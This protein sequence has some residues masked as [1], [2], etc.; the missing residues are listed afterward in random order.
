MSSNHSTSTSKSSPIILGIADNHDAGAAL[1]IDGKIVVAINQERIDRIK[2]S[3]FFPMGAID[4]VLEEANCKARDIDRVVVG[5]AFTPSAFLR[6]LPNVH[7]SQKKSGQFSPLLHAYL[8]YQTLLQQG[9]LEHFEY[10]LSK[11]IIERKLSSITHA[12][13]ML[14]DHHES[15]A[16]LAYRTQEQQRILVLTLDAMGDGNTATVWMGRDGT[17]IPLWKQSGLAAIN[18]F[19]SRITEILGFVPLRHEGK[20][21][22]LA[23]LAKP[24]KSLLAHFR[25]RYR[26]AGG[27]F[28]RIFPWPIDH[29]D[30]DYWTQVKK[31]PREVIA[32]TA[33]A[34]LEEVTTS[35]V[36]HWVKTTKCSSI[37]LAGGVFANVKLNQRL[38][39]HAN[40]EQI[41][42]AP[43]MGDG[44]LAVG[45]LLAY[46]QPPPRQMTDVFLGNS[47]QKIDINRAISRSHI[48]AI[49]TEIIPKIAELLSQNKYVAICRGRMEWGPR[50]LGNR[51]IFALATDANC[52]DKL[53][54][55]LHRSEF[56]PFAPIV[57][58]EDRDRF[59]IGL[60]KANYACRFMTVCCDVTKEFKKIAPAATHVDGTARPQIV[61][62]QQDPW[63]HELLTYLHV[64]YDISILIN[65]SFNIHEEPIV[66]T[67]DQAVRAFQQAQLDALLLEDALLIRM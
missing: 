54:V 46:C 43:N 55:K 1:W 41:W 30:D 23:A 20:I 10:R 27:R 66:S 31:Y 48:S 19:Y 36:L 21:T 2:N 51:S 13:V 29:P 62:Q 42:I 26:F 18:L 59:F 56:M 32:A 53:N 61:Y 16:Q 67:P 52:N 14:I 39:D 38:M 44:G 4:A 57:R 65:T 34:I 12:P 47:L 45:G 15:H 35:F 49:R 3:G 33:Q 6:L 50:A 37:A 7:H 58:S 17:L 60:S 8:Y 28:S 25:S 64:H 22:G 9:G 63:L 40:I 5:T 11:K 24:N